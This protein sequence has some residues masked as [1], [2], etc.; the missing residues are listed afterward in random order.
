MLL[1]IVKPIR[2]I[3]LFGLITSSVAWSQSPVNV[4]VLDAGHGAHDRG[5][6]GPTG[7]KEKHITLKLVM[8]VGHKI[9]ERF[10]N[11][12]VYY[13]RTSDVFI[14]IYERGEIANRHKA[15][16]FISIHCNANPSR[17]PYGTETYVM[18]LHKSDDNLEVAKR[19]NES[20]L[21]EEG[22]KKTYKGF[23]P[24]SPLAYIMLT[25]FQNAFLASSLSFASKIEKEF[26][27]YAERSSRGVKQAGFIVLWRTTMPSVLVETGFLSNRKEEKFLASEEGQEQI[28]ESIARAFAKYKEE[29]DNQ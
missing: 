21:Q 13:T 19:E 6:M 2:L 9:K 11:V 17:T 27:H 1:N 24:N 14:P 4:V 22:Y 15:D 26:K 8:A 20:I 16:L 3:I 25:N 29:M 23:D 7:V 18:G 5:C 12:K 10:P 28:A